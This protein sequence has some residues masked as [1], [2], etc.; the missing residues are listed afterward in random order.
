MNSRR[1]SMDLNGVVRPGGFSRVHPSPGTRLVLLV[2]GYN[3]NPAEASESYFALRR[4][5]DDLIRNCGI[6][7]AARRSF[8]QEIWEF[9]WPGFQSLSHVSATGGTRSLP[10]SVASALTYP[11]EVA[12]ARAWVPNGLAAYLNSIHPSEIFFVGHSLGCR[13]VLET[14]VRLMVPT[15]RIVINGFMLMAGA[16]P[17]HLLL[18]SKTFFS[19]TRTAKRRYC[20]YSW[21]DAVLA[22]AFPPGQIAAGEA[23]LYGLPVA[24]GL[25]G[26][27]SIFYDL[28]NNTNLGHGGYW[29]NGLFKGQSSYAD[30]LSQVL[31]VVVDRSLAENELG[32]MAK[33][34]SSRALPN[35][36]I[37]IRELM[38][39]DWL[40]DS[41]QD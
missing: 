36:L 8:Q 17:I 25:V 3:N 7:D 12:K 34:C 41:Y 32:L 9:Y 37:S 22:S 29:K 23:P 35:R 27:P 2:H 21:Q 38:G 40:S 5:V 10:E 6:G 4:N 14:I 39:D 26:A 11:L 16:I 31:G 13:V 28:R 30:L 20:L 15:Q 18:E 33:A 1:L 19:H 24:T